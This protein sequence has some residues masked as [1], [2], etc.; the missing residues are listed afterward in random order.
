[1][2]GRTSLKE[3][4]RHPRLRECY[5]VEYKIVSDDTFLQSYRMG[6]TRDLGRGGVCFR[7]H[8]P[9]QQ[10]DLLALSVK[11]PD[12]STSIV[13]LARVL[14][15]EPVES[16]GCYPVAVEFLWSGWHDDAIQREISDFIK[17]KLRE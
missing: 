12:L 10:G 17:K 16:D 14:R 8:E 7:T 15:R 6:V 2:Q 9:L 13:A 3:R 1:M 11:V 5:G 4:R